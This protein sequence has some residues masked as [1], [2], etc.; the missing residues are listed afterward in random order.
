ME[1]KSVSYAAV[2][3]L[4]AEHVQKLFAKVI[5]AKRQKIVSQI[6]II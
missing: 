1:M 4:L 5:F 2:S 6:N 3:I